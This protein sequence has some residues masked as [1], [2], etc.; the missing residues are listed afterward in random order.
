MKAAF[1]AQLE[2]ERN[3]LIELKQTLNEEKKQKEDLTEQLQ[4]FIDQNQRLNS[5]LESQKLNEKLSKYF[6]EQDALVSEVS[7]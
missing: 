6:D 2:K 7:S 5:L 4:M 1:T 3:K